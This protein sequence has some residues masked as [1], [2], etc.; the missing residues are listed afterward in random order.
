MRE[1]KPSRA[2]SHLALNTTEQQERKDVHCL[3]PY[4][5]AQ[6]LTPP[7]RLR[8]PSWLGPSLGS[9]HTLPNREPAVPQE[10]QKQRPHGEGGKVPQ[11]EGVVFAHRCPQNTPTL[12]G[13]QLQ[14]SPITGSAK[15]PSSWLCFGTVPL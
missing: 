12:G 4:Y 6:L 2:K 13:T 9:C 5:W 8:Q 15:A 7:W 10:A 1:V 3:L 14:L 11:P